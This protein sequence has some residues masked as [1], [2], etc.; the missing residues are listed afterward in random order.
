VVFAVATEAQKQT[1]I[2]KGL[3]IAGITAKVEALKAFT[4][5]TQCFWCQGF[6]HNP[7]TC[8][9]RPKCRLCAGGH[10]TRQHK[11]NTCE[12]SGACDHL[13][14]K[15]S[16]C[17]GAHPANDLKCEVYRA[18]RAPKGGSRG[19]STRGRPGGRTRDRTG[20]RTRSYTEGS[21][22]APAV[23]PNKEPMESSE[24]YDTDVDMEPNA[25]KPK[26]IQKW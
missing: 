18:V 15:C 2:Q 6:N 4:P 23:G 11:C 16:N 8:R 3:I 13:R 22:N 1:L 5:T 21:T 26:D 7:R 24:E 25:T 9:K 20:G 19:V 14:P 10:P 17:G 12:A